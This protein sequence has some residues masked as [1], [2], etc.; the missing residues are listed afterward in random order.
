M[1]PIDRLVPYAGNPR[2]NGSAIDR[3]AASI[4][5]FGFKIPVLARSSGE[6]VDGHLPTR[7]GFFL[8]GKRCSSGLHQL[9][10]ARC[11]ISSTKNE[12]PGCGML[13]TAGFSAIGSE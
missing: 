5:E 4:Q 1:W 7:A 12:R 13:S 11:A 10:R 8:M 3:M 2:K 6:V 9:Y